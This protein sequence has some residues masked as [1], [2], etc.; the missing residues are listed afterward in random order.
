LKTLA[1]CSARGLMK[2]LEPNGFGETYESWVTRLRA[3]CSLRQKSARAMS[4]SESLSSQWPTPASGLPNDGEEPETWHARAAALKEKHQNGNGAGIPLAIAAK[5]FTASAWPTPASR[6][7]KGAPSKPYSERGGGTKGEA[8]DSFVQ[9]HWYTPNVPNGG[10][11]LTEDTS[12]TGMTPDGIKRQVGLENQAKQWPTPTS[13][14][15]AESHQPGNSQSMNITLD[16][17]SSLRDQM[18]YPVGG[19][20]LKER[21]SLNPLFVEWLMGWPPGW[22][23]LAWIDLGCSEMEWSHWKARMASEL[24]RIGLPREAPPEQMSLFG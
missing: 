4:A 24:L 9:H 16:L 2:S 14:S 22:T 10:R 7:W 12:P 17:A 13:L 15:F 21:R 6:D 18:T 5:D 19:I 20:P 23:L 3:D 8:L 11:T 1:A